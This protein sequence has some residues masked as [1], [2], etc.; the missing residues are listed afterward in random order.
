[1]AV[2]VKGICAVCGAALVHL[3]LG[4]LYCWG[5][6]TVYVTSYMR[7]MGQTGIVYGMTSWVLALAISC[8][9]LFMLLGGLL[10]KRF[11]A[12]F[13]ATLGSL[14]LTS[15]VLISSFTCRSLFLFCCTY[16]M[17]FGM[18]VGLCYSA[19][20]KRA[21]DWH[22]ERRGL[23]SGIVVAGFGGGAMIFDEVQ[24]RFIN[25][26][27]HRPSNVDGGA[28]YFTSADVDMDRIPECFLL[29]AACYAV[30]QLIGVSL[31]FPP[32]ASRMRE[33][34][35]QQAEAQRS[36][37]PGPGTPRSESVEFSPSQI[38]RKP[39]FWLLWC[40][41]FSLGMAV[42]FTASFFKVV[43]ESTKANDTALGYIA[44]ASSLFNAAGRI[45]FGL[46][47]DRFGYRKSGFL[48]T[49]PQALLVFT[50]PLAANWGVWPY[51][52]WTCLLF[53]CLGG[54]FALFP[55]ACS[56][57]FGSVNFAANYGLLFSCNVPGAIMSAALC[58]VM[59]AQL[60]VTGMTTVVGAILLI[61]F[62]MV[63]ITPEPGPSPKV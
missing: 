50:Y 12:R 36:L 48:V 25:P 58:A 27:G 55:Y 3:T 5:N 46:S 56:K 13:P 54:T 14:T 23:I 8:Q 18:G 37:T 32:P 43:G 51:A 40:T 33:L 57:A 47:C 6:L 62:F 59:T 16:G 28:K 52:I 1:M 63:C 19:L 39:M 44:S 41:F 17:G 60:G 35:Q 15:M 26:D 34:R 7:E 61:A 9:S 22:P 20:L 24:A 49:G 21:V 38:V 31:L 42:V 10:E 29:M 4:T 45:T 2:P 53:F 30:M 11:G